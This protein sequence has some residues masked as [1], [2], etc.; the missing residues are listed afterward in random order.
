[1]TTCPN[2]D[3]TYSPAHPALGVPPQ[4]PQCSG[5]LIA[6]QPPPQPGSGDIWRLVIADMEQRRLTGI[7]R[8]GT[9]L[10]AGNGRDALVDA[11]QEA[12]DLCVYLRQVIEERRGLRAALEDIEA[13]AVANDAMAENAASH[14]AA[15]SHYGIADGLRLAAKIIRESMP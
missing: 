11:A 3:M 14:D 2:C 12:M 9:P 5:Q 7:E 13:A 6:D 1:M 4:C 8:Y 10:Q 15:T